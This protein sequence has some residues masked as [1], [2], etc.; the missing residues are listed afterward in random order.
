MGTPLGGFCMC[1]C[2]VLYMAFKE[3]EVSHIVIA[4]E[5]CNP[6]YLRPTS[7]QL[8]GRIA[9]DTMIVWLLCCS[10]LYVLS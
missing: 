7:S 1:C 9:P 3:S 4:A 6:L 5:Q 2:S 8:P 10:G